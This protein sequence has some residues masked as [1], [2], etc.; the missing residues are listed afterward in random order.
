MTINKTS[1]Y[2]EQ[3]LLVHAQYDLAIEVIGVFLEGNQADM[4]TKG[5]EFYRLLAIKYPQ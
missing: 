4:K 5:V 3:V 2:T 1:H